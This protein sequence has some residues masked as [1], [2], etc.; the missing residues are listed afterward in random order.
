MRIPSSS[1]PVKPLIQGFIVSLLF[2]IA[3]AANAQAKA[4][5]VA[6]TAI[7]PDTLCN[8]FALDNKESVIKIV[9]NTA[10]RKA[11]VRS[12]EYPRLVLR[13][14]SNTEQLELIQ[15]YGNKDYNVSEFRVSAVLK[16]DSNRRFV[17]TTIPGFASGKN[18]TL[19]MSSAQVQKL[20]GAKG[21]LLRS[22]NK[23][24]VQYRIT[25]GAYMNTHFKS[26][27]YATYTFVD[28]KLTTFSYGFD[29]E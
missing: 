16:N 14:A 11:I 9:G 21:Q 10:W 18:I 8:G 23:S 29:F 24:I 13:N 4:Y 2:F 7:T 25:S 1:R 3:E 22:N 28:D 5:P 12:S 15:H 6:A 26:M 27:Y 20:W 17:K 19:G